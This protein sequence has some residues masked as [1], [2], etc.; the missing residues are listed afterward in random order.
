MNEPTSFRIST[1]A[2]GYFFPSMVN[3]PL[4][5]FV[6]PKNIFI[7]VDF[8]APFGPR[9][10]YTAPLGICRLTFDTAV[11]SAYDFVKF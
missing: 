5:G 3:E 6:S 4:V 8:P 1:L 7:V 10:P 11:K 9:K 2:S